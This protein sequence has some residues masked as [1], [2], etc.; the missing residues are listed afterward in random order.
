MSA[1]S[2][3]LPLKEA[4]GDYYVD[5]DIKPIFYGTVSG[6]TCEA[7]AY[8][9]IDLPVINLMKDTNVLKVVLENIDGTEIA[10]RHHVVSTR[11]KID[12]HPVVARF[13]RCSA[14]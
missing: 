10:P 7:G 14:V 5:Q 11:Q 8:G 4:A 2:A 9:H 13:K 12:I 1:L 6:V 3:T